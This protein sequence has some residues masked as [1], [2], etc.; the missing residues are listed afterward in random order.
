MLDVDPVAPTPARKSAIPIEISKLEDVV[1]VKLSGTPRPEEIVKMLDD[2]NALIAKDASLRVL[3]DETGL[4]PS[5][6]GPGDIGRFVG[7]WR[8][9]A[10]LRSTRMAVFV[11]NLAMYGL[12]RMFEGLADAGGH[13]SVFRGRADAVAWLLNS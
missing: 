9:A 7:S 2:L 13:M 11:P 5:F 12:N 10:A 4:N 8:R 3:I 1:F 6:V